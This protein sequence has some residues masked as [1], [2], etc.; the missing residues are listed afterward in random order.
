MPTDTAQRV[1]NFVVTGE[2]RSGAGAVV[3]GLN[4]RKDAVC[5][6]DLFHESEEVRRTAHLKYYGECKDDTPCWF[7]EGET[8]PWQYI[9]NSILDNPKKGESAVGFYLPCRALLRYELCD[10]FDQR[11]KEGD[12]SVIQVIRNPIACYV[13]LKQAE[14]TGEWTRAWNAPLRAAPPG[15]IRVI[16]DDLVQF[17]RSHAATVSKIRAA[18]DDRLEIQ[19]RDLVFD[20]QVVMRKV[21]D[22][23]ELT[24]LPELIKPGIRR[25]RNRPIPE[26]ISNLSE[27]KALLPTEYRRMI[28]EDD[29]V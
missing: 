27:L 17:C 25:L 16:A 6:V 12:F 3:T 5:H 1:W 20:Y 18:C 26:R 8:N 29:M 19:Y 9:N 2:T 24:E 21:F 7:V 14:L 15:P 23:V 4:N 13:S 11:G 22:F 28:E 10:L